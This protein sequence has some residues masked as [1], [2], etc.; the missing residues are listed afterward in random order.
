M[1]GARFR[2][3]HCFFHCPLI[4]YRNR[5]PRVTTAHWRLA[6]GGVA[7]LTHAAAL[8]GRKYEAGLEVWADG[9]RLTL[10]KPYWPECLLR[11]RSGE[12]AVVGMGEEVY[13]VHA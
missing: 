3:Y 1:Y 4:S 2:A 12:S 7:C 6:G 8:Q 10:E 5:I 9:L 13:S 11:I